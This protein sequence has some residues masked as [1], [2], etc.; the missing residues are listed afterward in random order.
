MNKVVM[1]LMVDSIRA[2]IYFDGFLPPA[3]LPVRYKRV[4]QAGKRLENYHA[5]YDTGVPPSQSNDLDSSETPLFVQRNPAISGHLNVPDPSFLVPAIIEALAASDAYGSLTRVAPGEAD[6]YC[7]YHVQKYGGVI[8]TSDSDLLLYDLGR[9]GSVVWL[10]DIEL[11]EQVARGP[12]IFALKYTPNS[13]EQQMRLHP[14][15]G[16]VQFGYLASLEPSASTGELL[17]VF[18]SLRRATDEFKSDL[19]T[20]VGGYLQP[21]FLLEQMVH[22]PRVASSKL[23]HLDTRVSELVVQCNFDHPEVLESLDSLKSTHLVRIF[24]PVLLDDP[25]RASA[26]E[27]SAM[28]RELAYCMLQQKIQ[29]RQLAVVEFKRLQTPPEGSTGKTVSQSNQDPSWLIE[30]VRRIR[31]GMQTSTQPWAAL[32]IHMDIMWSL[33]AGK[34]RVGSLGTLQK[35]ANGSINASSWESVHLATQILAT[36]YSCRIL[37]QILQHSVEQAEGELLGCMQDLHEILKPLPPLVDFPTHRALIDSLSRAKEDESFMC[38]K[39]LFTS[40]P[41]VHQQLAAVWESPRK[42]K[43]RRVKGSEEPQAVRRK[44]FATTTQNPYEL[45]SIEEME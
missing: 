43:K 17:S 14:I 41:H 4:I 40:D 35:L 19:D 36:M 7:A 37:Q 2:A 28:I 21:P 29:P 30:L 23:C 26:W 39:D 9:D 11:Q 45:L 8:L 44:T 24:L 31:G 1:G 38:L 32:A 42:R 34:E 15:G 6:S 16:L 20:F 5:S 18:R 22:M 33:S 10:E 25:A 3:K 13:I 12:C 27:S